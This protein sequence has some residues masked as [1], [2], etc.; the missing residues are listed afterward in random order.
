MKGSIL[1]IAAGLEGDI[2]PEQAATPGRADRL[3]AEDKVWKATVAADKTMFQGSR[4]VTIER[5]GKPVLAS[6]S[7][8]TDLEINAILGIKA[9]GEVPAAPAP[10]QPA[11]PKAQQVLDSGTAPKF[12]EAVKAGIKAPYV[13]AYIS[14]LGGPERPTIMISASLDPQ[15]SWVNNIFQNSRYLQLHIDE[16][17]VLECFSQDYRLK[18]KIGAAFRKTRVKTPEEAISKINAYISKANGQVKAAIVKASKVAD[19]EVGQEVE[20]S[21]GNVIEVKEKGT[22]KK[23]GPWLDVE[24]TDGEVSRYW[25]N[26]KSAPELKD[27]SDHLDVSTLKSADEEDEE[28]ESEGGSGE[29]VKVHIWAVWY[30]KESPEVVKKAGEEGQIQIGLGAGDDQYDGLISGEADAKL[31]VTAKDGMTE[32]RLSGDIYVSESDLKELWLSPYAMSSEDE[33][34]DTFDANGEALQAGTA[35]DS[36]QGDEKAPEKKAGKGGKVKGAGKDKGAIVNVAEGDPL[37][38]LEDHKR[39][40]VVFNVDDQKEGKMYQAKE[41]SLADLRKNEGKWQLAVW[42]V[43]MDDAKKKAVELERRR[44]DLMPLPD[45]WP[46]PPAQPDGEGL[47]TY[48]DENGRKTQRAKALPGNYAPHALEKKDLEKMPTEREKELAMRRTDIVAKL[49]VKGSDTVED[50]MLRHYLVTAL[51]ASNDESTEAGGEPLDK[52]HGIQDFTAEAMNKAKADCES[53]TQK[54][55]DLTAGVDPE[56][57]GHDFFLTRN[58]HGA[59]FWDRPELYGGKENAD[60]LTALAKQFGS[61]T[62]YLGDDKRIHFDAVLAQKRIQWIVDEASDAFMD[63]Q[64]NIGDTY[65]IMDALEGETVA[66]AFETKPMDEGAKKLFIEKNGTDAH[67]AALQSEPAKLDEIVGLVIK[68]C[69]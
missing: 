3:I 58:G 24:F 65:S 23:R 67:K 29:E 5:A 31:E 9:E 43:D 38:A 52:N 48:T 15:D 51:W 53:F 63:E 32:I 41:V 28:E 8:L 6:L 30:V 64:G 66:E 19:F 1:S 2:T 40:A 35:A 34:F 37:D 20:D 7:E 57:V 62:P 49:T 68:E 25:D 18:A 42:C 69:L 16:K 56:Q 44:T 46:V 36:G 17:G 10:E 47:E 61:A 21:E 39:P 60:K 59:G 4:M 26:P 14:T 13:N 50:P 45:H 12:L 27:V 55:G 11:Q 54:A 22:D 33:E